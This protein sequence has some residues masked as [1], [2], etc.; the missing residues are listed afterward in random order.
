MI[1]NKTKAI[2]ESEENS[3]ILCDTN[4]HTSVANAKE[5]SKWRILFAD[6]DEGG[7]TVNIKQENII[8]TQGETGMDEIR[9][10]QRHSRYLAGRETF[11]HLEVGFGQRKKIQTGLKLGQTVMMTVAQ[12]FLSLTCF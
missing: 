1:G 8:L 11:I 2:H 6:T 7:S 12:R 10:E 9:L 4:I 5:T 3:G